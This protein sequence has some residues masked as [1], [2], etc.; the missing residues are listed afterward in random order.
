MID[1]GRLLGFPFDRR[2]IRDSRRHARLGAARE[3]R[4]GRRA[5]LQV[6]PPARHLGRRGRGAVGAGAAR[7]AAPS[8]SRTAA[9]TEIALYDGL[10]PQPARLAERSISISARWRTGSRRCCRPASTTRPSWGRARLWQA[11]WEPLLRHMAGLGRA[12]ATARSRR[13]TTSATRIATCW[14][15]AAGRP[16]SRPRSRPA[17]RG[18]RVILADSDTEFGGALLR[19]PTPIVDGRRP[20]GRGAVAELAA[21]RRSRCCR[22]P[23]CSATTTTII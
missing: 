17:G 7:N 8:P 11:L 12:P 18:A 3:R 14:W 15:S 22:G 19:R 10:A 6:P 5:Q 4:Q 20:L 16:G 2:D 23:R 21:C 9:P 13:A 1:R